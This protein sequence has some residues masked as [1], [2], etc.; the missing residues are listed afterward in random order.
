MSGLRYSESQI[1]YGLQ[2]AWLEIVGGAA[3]FDCDTRI[4]EHMKSDGTWDEIDFYDLYREL[5]EFFGFDC[6]DE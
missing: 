3:K 2:E 6:T 5:E 1:I 4:Y